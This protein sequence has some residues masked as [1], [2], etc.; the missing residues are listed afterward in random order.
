MKGDLEAG[1]FLGLVYSPRA[2]VRPS[3]D[4]GGVGFGGLEAPGITHRVWD[5]YAESPGGFKYAVCLPNGSRQV[6][7]ILQRVVGN[8]ETEGG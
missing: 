1:S 7:H 8:H 4:E 3:H 2:V 6:A 5:A